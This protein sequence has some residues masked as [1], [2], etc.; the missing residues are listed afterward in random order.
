[1]FRG[2][3]SSLT[4]GALFFASNAQAAFTREPWIQDAT[5]DSVTIAWEGAA[6]GG[7]Q[8]LTYGAGPAL[9]QAV[10]GTFA[11]GWLYTATVTG[12]PA[13]SR[14]AYKV[15]SGADESPVGSFVTA[16][17][18]A[19]PFRFGV[20]GDNRSDAAGH[21]SV[22]AA[23]IPFAPDFMLNT[24]DIVDGGNYTEFFDIE[25]NLLRNSVI[26]P[27]PGNHDAPTEYQYGFIRPEYYS[28]R[29]G[30]AFFLAV[31]SEADY[32]Q[33]S[34]QIQWVEAQLVA[35]KA[36]TTI[37]W[38]VAY[39][40]HPVYSSGSHGD[41][42]SVITDLNPLYIAHGVDFVFNGHDHN[43]ERI[44]RDNVIYVVAGGG[45]VDPRAMGAPV[46]GAIFSE[47]V[48]HTVIV[49]IDGG[50]LT[51]KV[52]RPDGSLLDERQVVKG[53]VS[54]QP[55]DDP[56]DPN[57]PSDPADPSD[58]V[59]SDL[60]GGCACAIGAT[61]PATLGGFLPAAILLVGFV[62]ARRKR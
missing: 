26:F 61:T 55:G 57:D 52:Y 12:L 51:M 49:D 32:S 60:G 10:A 18:V 25:K 8:S 5:K 6:A 37:Q 7:T 4:M 17:A 11:S 13:S 58:P 3:A 29:W 38:I 48:R 40:H 50:V 47:S 20:T 9:D 43:Y 35:A 24:G 1:M 62:L 34:T 42:A 54:G 23:T 33:G 36:D 59:S 53:P 2:L 16:P 44:E 46:T 41:T 15:T 39:H 56:G 27:A 31:S 30:N 19:E 45:G 22:V 21:A 28:F 14:F